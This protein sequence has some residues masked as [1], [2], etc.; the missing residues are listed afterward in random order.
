M[1]LEIKE[2]VPLAP[3]TTFKIGGS[4]KYFVETRTDEDL[5]E[6]L[7][8]AQEKNARFTILAGGSNVLVSDNVFDGLVIHLA[9]KGFSF[10]GNELAAD[11]GC[12]LLELIRIASEKNLGGWEKLA[13]I[14]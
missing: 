9:S 2:N 8:W 14:P 12:N 10:A 13:G 6:A 4:A 1:A 3:L 7:D 11:A 5:R